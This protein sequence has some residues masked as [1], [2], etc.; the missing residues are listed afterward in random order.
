MSVESI[1][2][3][4]GTDVATIAPEASVRNL[5]ARKKYRRAFGDER[6]CDCWHHF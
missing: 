6:R 5:A 1:L 4:K 3:L 2:K